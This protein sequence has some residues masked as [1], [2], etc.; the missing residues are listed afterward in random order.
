VVLD[1]GDQLYRGCPTCRRRYWARDGVAETCKRD[2]A[3]LEPPRS[4]RRQSWL[5][6]FPT[7][8][9]ADAARDEKRTDVRRGT[10]APRTDETL[11]DFLAG[12]L[13]T[14]SNLRPTTREQYEIAVRSYVVPRI[15]TTKLTDVRATTL[16]RLY[17]DLLQSGGRNGQSLRPK[18]VRNVHLVLHRAFVS[19]VKAG[20]ITFNPADGCDAVPEAESRQSRE[21]RMRETV[22]SPADVRTFLAGVR[23]DRLYTAWLLLATT[24]LRRGELLGLP[25]SAVSLERGTVRVEQAL[26]LLRGAP[27]ITETKSDSSAA[28]IA[29]DSATVT[30]LREHRRRQLEEKLAA[31]PAYATSDLVFVDELGAPIH[32]DAF[33]RRFQSL[34]RRAG[35][36]PVRVHDM[37]HGY[38]SA[39]LAAGLSMKVISE[40]LRH[41]GIGITADLYTHLSPEVDRAAAES[42]AAFILGN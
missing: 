10:F 21:R 22:W 11:A 34:A 24:G 20:R 35:L 6:G 16:D 40:R 19:A 7:K 37:R 38:A 31:G 13:A 33:L 41:A 14:R 29:I 2:G 23:D 4:G 28:E 36:R 8:R 17:A 9:D 5:G 15:G 26:V 18:T 42:G 3:P 39:L 30:A 32:P 1:L 25:W 27:T 12:W